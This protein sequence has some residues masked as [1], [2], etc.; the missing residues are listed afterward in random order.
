MPLERQSFVVRCDESLIR[1]ID[2]L[3]PSAGYNSRNEFIKSLMENAV[4]DTVKLQDFDYPMIEKRLVKQC[5]KLIS[6]EL[7]IIKKRMDKIRENQCFK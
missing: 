4:D 5:Q 2:L 6:R 7:A 3:W 1:A